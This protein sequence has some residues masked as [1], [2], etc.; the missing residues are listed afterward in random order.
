MSLPP[1]QWPDDIKRLFNI[2][3][4]NSEDDLCG[5]RKTK[6]IIDHFY[7]VSYDCWRR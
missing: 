7:W 2:L 6:H 4:I 1:M 5:V 3:V